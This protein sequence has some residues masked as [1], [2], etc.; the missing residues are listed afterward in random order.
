[1]SKEFKVK[2]VTKAK[3]VKRAS[4]VHKEFRDLRVTKVHEEFKVLKD[5]KVKPECPNQFMLT[6]F[7]L[8]MLVR[9]MVLFR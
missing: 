7:S 1:V 9:P 2:R 8:I 6:T 3:R 5:Q 4:Q